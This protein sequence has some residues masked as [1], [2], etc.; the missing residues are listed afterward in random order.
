MA[1][2]TIIYDIPDT[3]PNQFNFTA[4]T[5]VELNTLYTSNVITIT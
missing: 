4:M 1:M 3:T 5:G 2:D